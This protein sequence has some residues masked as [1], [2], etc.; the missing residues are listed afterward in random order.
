MIFAFAQRSVPSM[1]ESPQHSDR[2]DAN[3]GGVWLGV[4]VR[5]PEDA[6]RFSFTTASGPGGQNVN[7]RSTRVTLRI[8]ITDIPINTAAQARLRK[9]AGPARMTGDDL[10]ITDGRR[11]SQR[12][13]KQSCVD[14]LAAL[15]RQALPEPKARRA[16]K[17]SRR[18][19]ARRLDAKTKHGEKKRR[20]TRDSW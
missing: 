9:L 7:R 8:A 11:R 12:D 10:L 1:D 6:L 19:Q 2:S 18:A 16:T 13:N 5:V 15:V 14:R 20:R 4:G 3:A 17:P